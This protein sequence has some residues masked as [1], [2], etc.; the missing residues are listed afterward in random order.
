MPQR[1]H[2]PRLCGIYYL[3]IYKPDSQGQAEANWIPLIRL[4]AN[5]RISNHSANVTITQTF[6]PPSS[7]TPNAKIPEAKYSFPVYPSSSVVSFVARIKLDGAVIKTIRGV[8][9]AL[10]TAKK[11][12]KEAVARGETAGFLEQ[13]EEDVFT[14]RLGNI[15][16]VEGTEVE[17]DVG[18]VT[19]LK[20][21]SEVDGIRFTIPTAI[22]PRYGSNSGGVTST[23]GKHVRDGL[24]MGVEIDMSGP[25]SSVQSPSHPIAVTVGSLNASGD[26]TEWDNKLAFARLSQPTAYLDNDFILQ[27]ICKDSAAPTALLET[28]LGA[29]GTVDSAALM[30]TLVPRFVIPLVTGQKN[31]KEIIFM[32]DRSGSMFNKIEPLKSALRVFLKSLPPNDGIRFD[33]CSFGSKY[34]FLF[35]EKR[36]GEKPGSRLY[37]QKSLKTALDHVEDISANYGGTEIL[38]PISEAC[39][40]VLRRNKER[41][42][43]LAA[44]KENEED[45][46]ELETEVLLLTDGEVWDTKQLF[47]LV[48]KHT[49]EWRAKGKRTDG[50]AGIRVF[51][52]GIGSDVSHGFV[53]GLAKAGGGY[54]MTVGDNERFEGKVV[55]MLKAALGQRIGGYELTF[56]GM[57]EWGVTSSETSSTV[58]PECDDGF[59][60][61]N[62]PSITTE[63]DHPVAQAPISLFDLSANPDSSMHENTK[64]AVKFA[65]PPA[66]IRAPHIIPP[67]FPFNRT[68]V[69]L[70]ISPRKS[71]TSLP[72][73]KNVQLKA[74]TSTGQPLELAIPVTEITSP[75]SKTLHQL[76]TKKYL[77][78]L[79]AGE[80]WIHS[81]C[82]SGR[83]VECISG[84]GETAKKSTIKLHSPD[85]DSFNE[86]EFE[87]IVKREGERIGVQWGVVGKWTAFVA[88]EETDSGRKPLED[89]MATAVEYNS[90]YSGYLGYSG[91]PAFLTGKGAFMHQPLPASPRAFGSGPTA[92]YYSATTTSCSSAALGAPLSLSARSTKCSSAAPAAPCAPLSLSAT[93]WRKRSDAAPS[94]AQGFGAETDFE[95]FWDITSDLLINLWSKAKK[96]E[97]G[98]LNIANLKENAA[99]LP[100]NIDKQLK[101]KVFAT[102]LVLV[103]LQHRLAGERDTWELVFDK[104]NDWLAANAG[105][106]IDSALAKAKEILGVV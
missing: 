95:G 64:P 75:K 20:H 96:V 3:P 90:G 43:R 8:V 104:G 81:A 65:I 97:S 14:M 13:I 47:D 73:P 57:E 103:W 79:K 78:D 49:Q 100:D 38:A 53:E 2:I 19:E 82:G 50:R 37:S 24:E 18:Y 1:V 52:L 36:T 21:D 12:Y 71:S 86:D 56:D 11:E 7:N 106:N 44:G 102:C 89:T 46:A 80:S 92:R 45:H 9:K 10:P 91:S 22:A 85:S 88:L 39:D 28:N 54:C 99:K 55:R 29:N 101:E 25:V 70:L 72:L 6:A 42:E 27:V 87:D 59:E 58:T 16:Q 33:I 98:Q 34:T 69:Y 68:N 83:K 62:S 77:D 84:E 94:C 60:M 26:Q 30:L 41:N 5:A 76:A 93:S 105:G 67:V 51:T 15:P 32:V 63:K 74:V 48:R 23:S 17:V 4:T 61:V 31:R 40:R 35:D 66:L